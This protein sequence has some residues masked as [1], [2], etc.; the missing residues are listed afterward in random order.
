MEHENR[1]EADTAGPVPDHPER[2]AARGDRPP[3]R[4][5]EIETGET[6]EKEIGRFTGLRRSF[7]PTGVISLPVGPLVLITWLQAI[8]LETSDIQGYTGITWPEKTQYR[9]SSRDLTHLWQA[10]YSG[11]M[12][13]R[14]RM[15]PEPVWRRLKVLAAERAVPVNDIAIEALKAYVEKIDRLEARRAAKR[16]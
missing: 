12:E 16:K 7:G 15:I 5:A 4:P 3:E 9:P 14:V 1:P 2:R 6:E 8:L 11:A 13:A 10:W